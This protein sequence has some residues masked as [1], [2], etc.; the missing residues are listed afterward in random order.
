MWYRTLIDGKQGERFFSSAWC[1]DGSSAPETS[2]KWDTSGAF[3]IYNG[4]DYPEVSGSAAIYQKNTLDYQF[5]QFI[6][7]KIKQNDW[8]TIKKSG[9]TSKGEGIAIEDA[10]GNFSPSGNVKNNL[11]SDFTNSTE[12]P[13][14]NSK[15]NWEEF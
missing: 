1:A 7:Y 12:V 13:T 8:K 3:F 5:E 6:Q 2:T 4:D 11:I 15:P 10:N 9:W 14:T